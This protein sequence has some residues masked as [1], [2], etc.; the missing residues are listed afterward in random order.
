MPTIIGEKQL[1]EYIHEGKIIQN[2]NM[3]SAEGIKYDFHLGNRFLKAGFNF[4]KSYDELVAR[5]QAIVEP[6][7][8]VFVMTAERVE[9]PNNMNVQL[10]FKRKI[11]HEGISLLGGTSIDPGYCGYLVFG[12][13]NVAGKNFKLK[14]G[15]KIVGATFYHLSDE[16]AIDD[17]SSKPN[18][19]ED[20]PDDLVEL[21]ENYKPVNPQVINTR[22]NDLQMR[23]DKDRDALLQKLDVVDSRIDS[24]GVDVNI[25]LEN[26]EK[27][28]EQQL[29][30]SNDL[31][32]NKIQNIDDSLTSVSEDMN[33]IKT[34]IIT[35]K[36]WVKV[37][38]WIAG[39]I[40]AIVAGIA[41]GVFG[42]IINFFSK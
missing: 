41:T 5:D 29:H 31:L 13:H 14:P 2:G 7:E 39:I 38:T 21:I 11:G 12:I 15:R 26:L 30:N 17:S 24:L 42:N 34:S 23:L 27:N 22:L 37:L 36:V 33:S 9:I 32:S 4:E 28:F 16:E 20:F 6:G 3:D 40:G 18:P 10:N 25:K 19:I 8:V 1:K 35:A